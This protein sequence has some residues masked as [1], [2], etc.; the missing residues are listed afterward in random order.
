[1]NKHIEKYLEGYLKLDKP[2]FSVL[3]T[4]KWGSGKTYFIDKFIE[5]NIKE[6]EIKFIK[7]SL[8]GLKEVDSIDEQIF[9]I[10]HPVLGNKYIRLGGNIAKSAFKLGIKLDWN[11]DSKSDGTGTVD[12]SKFNLLDFFSDKNESNIKIIFVF[13]DLERTD[14][15]L[16]EVLGYINY[17]VEQS[18]FKVILLANDEKIIED[19]VKNEFT[20]Y[21]EFKEKV[22]GKT[23]EVQHD[24]ETILTSFIKENENLKKS[25]KYLK[26]NKDIIQDIYLQGNYNNLRHIKQILLDFEYFIKKV[27]KNYLKNEYFIHD[28]VNVFFLLSIEI[29]AGKLNKNELL[30]HDNLARYMTSDENRETTNFENILKKYELINQYNLMFS[31]QLLVKILF[32]VNINEDELNNEILNLQY[33]GKEQE[34]WRNLWS[35]VDLEDEEFIKYLNDVTSKFNNNEYIEHSK[36]LSVFGILLGLSKNGLYDI[37]INE[38]I[39]KQKKNIDN[40]ISNKLWKENLYQY[41]SFSDYSLGY[42][43]KDSTEFMEIK[44]YIEEKSRIAFDNGLIP[45]AKK[46]LDDYNQENIDLIKDKLEQEFY[47]IPIFSKIDYKEYIKMIQKV[48][49]KNLYYIFLPYKTR[50]EDY[51][52]KENLQLKNDLEFWESVYENILNNIVKDTQKMKHYRLGYFKENIKKYILDKL[53]DSS[54]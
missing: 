50:Y 45:K 48:K 36:V 29:K 4:G 15:E 30:N 10:L 25:K 33:F 12:L 20:K 39:K 32:E 5:N 23:F 38:L 6:D 19:E 34:S 17:L 51:Q 49:H 44:D 26:K 46:I 22:I 42:H 27:D 28:L 21:I 18:D 41:D 8:F 40:L 43:E 9:Q 47:N 13:D 16:T 35:Y 14:I 7:I 54:K 52:L 3:L 24:F 2:E 31:Q 37:S 53:R 11:D 1:M